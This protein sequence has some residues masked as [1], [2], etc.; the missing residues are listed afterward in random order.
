MRKTIWNAGLTAFFAAALLWTFPL[1]LQAAPVLPAGLSADGQSLAGQTVEEAQETLQK[2]IDSMKGQK[3]TLA[4]DG[5]EVETT[6]EELGFHWSNT[7]V[8]EKAAE[9]YAGGSLVKQY[10]TQKDLSEA[11]VELTLETGV[12][13]G[14]VSIFVDKHCEGV[15]AEPQNASI[16]RQDGAFVI[17]DS[18]VGKTVDIE[19]TEGALNEAL[20]DGLKEPVFAEAVIKE[21]QPEITSDDLAGIQDVLGTCT[22]DFS[23]SGASRST[24]LKVGA[25]KLNGHVL[26]PGDVLSGYECLQPFTT[27]NGYRT[28]S[29]YENGRVV[30]SIGGGVCQLATTLYDASLAAELEIVQRQNHSMI[31]DYVK[32]SMDAA[33]AGTVKDIKIK[34]NYDTPI[35]VEGYT[36][37]KKLT[38]T[39]YGKE[40]R[41]ENRTVQYVSE[42]VGTTSPG[43]P[44]LVVDN[45]LAPGARVKVQSSHTGRRSRLWKVV[46][47]DGQEQERTLVSEDTYYASKAIY[48][49]GPE[50]PAVAEEPSSAEENVV[51]AP[52]TGVDGG[53][54]VSPQPAPEAPA[55]ETSP[56]PAAEPASEAA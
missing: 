45:S 50:A 7:D 23:S 18:V 56:A 40:S 43:D 17:T 22:T 1:T 19:A 21:E 42:T 10:M 49:V 4:V 54:G 36:E 44:Q 27:A 9:Q 34:N 53:P 48:R 6:A 8:V 38:F 31:V 26:M 2:Y 15:N 11:P 3:I 37:G 28:A 25:E 24:N 20:K 14:K 12:D 5:R 46:T 55:P 39:I 30:D 51:Q 35:Y 33:I 13:S 29:A 32:P 47:V 41:P 16:T 52:V